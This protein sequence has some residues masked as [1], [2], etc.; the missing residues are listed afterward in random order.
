MHSFSLYLRE[1]AGVRALHMSFIAG[2][3]SRVCLRLCE[4]HQPYF[5]QNKRIE[6]LFVDQHPH[7]PHCNRNGQILVFFELVVPEDAIPY[8]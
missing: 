3:C 2:W 4:T 7:L 6:Q 5:S 8:A 1:R